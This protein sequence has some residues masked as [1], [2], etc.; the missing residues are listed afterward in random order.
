[1]FF[2]TLALTLIIF[3]GVLVVLI[4]A[5]S[6]RSRLHRENVIRLLEL[7]LIGR[8]TEQDWRLFSALSLRHNPQLELVRAR[9]LDIEER[10]YLKHNNG[11][12]FTQRGLAELREILDELEQAEY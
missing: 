6:S 1:M 2:L 8:A 4:W 9:C 7:V 12:L 5:R 10:E 3:F 11:I